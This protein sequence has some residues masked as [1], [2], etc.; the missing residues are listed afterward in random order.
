[1]AGDEEVIAISSEDESITEGYESKMLFV[2]NYYLKRYIEN[3][4]ESIS[5]EPP[6]KRQTFKKFVYIHALDNIS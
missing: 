1:M 4:S 5:D 2:Y 6:N 3:N